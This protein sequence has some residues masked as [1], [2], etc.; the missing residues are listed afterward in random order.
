M[1]TEFTCIFT[2][3]IC[4]HKTVNVYFVHN[5]CKHD[6][7]QHECFYNFEVFFLYTKSYVNETTENTLIQIQ[8]CGVI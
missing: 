7:L 2:D 6:K 4:I 3:H 8:P 1:I 5:N